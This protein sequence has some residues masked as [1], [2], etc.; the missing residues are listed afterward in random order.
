MVTRADDRPDGPGGVSRRRAQRRRDDLD[1]GLLP[2]LVGYHLRRAQIAVFQ[3]FSAATQEFAVT[4]GQFGVVVLIGTNEG[5]SQ[6]ELGEALGID[7]STM[8]A[9]ID[10]LQARG[11]VV[12]APSKRDRRSYA[13]RL[14]P[15]GRAFVD[16]MIPSVRAHEDAIAAN[17]TPDE[18]ADLI[19][20]LGKVAR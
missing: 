17:L 9:V 15:A 11:L 8:V 3:N 16:A 1:H 10:R 12:R 6:S 2:E 20:L 13:L 5:L 7:R 4:P 19:R 18:K 14:S